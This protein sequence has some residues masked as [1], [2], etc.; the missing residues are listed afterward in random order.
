MTTLI[1]SDHILVIPE[2]WVEAF[3][4]SK[5]MPKGFCST[6]GLEGCLPQK[7]KGYDPDEIARQMGGN[8]L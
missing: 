3:R 8:D 7:H 2:N 6:C 5:S 4:I 1:E